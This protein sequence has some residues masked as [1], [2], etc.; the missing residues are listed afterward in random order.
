MNSR[1]PM[2]KAAW[3][4]SLAIRKGIDSVSDPMLPC[5]DAKLLVRLPNWDLFLSA[6]ACRGGSCL[7]SLQASPSFRNRSSS[8]PVCFPSANVSVSPENRSA[9][10]LLAKRWAYHALRSRSLYISLLKA[11][12]KALS[13]TKKGGEKR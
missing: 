3:F 8:E 12:D 1:F 5:S 4:L 13:P 6:K 10:V 2:H 9:S 7:V 11:A